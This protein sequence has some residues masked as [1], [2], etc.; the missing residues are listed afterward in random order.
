MKKSERRYS[1]ATNA[2]LDHNRWMRFIESILPC[3]ADKAN[4][5]ALYAKATGHEQDIHTKYVKALTIAATTSVASGLSLVVDNVSIVGGFVTKLFVKGLNMIAGI[6]IDR[7]F[8]TGG[9]IYETAREESRTNLNLDIIERN[10][11]KCKKDT[12]DEFSKPI[13]DKIGDDPEDN[14]TYAG[15]DA[16]KRVIIDPA[17]YVYEGV[18]SNRVEGVKATAYYR[19]EVEDIYGDIH[20][21]VQV[22]NAEDYAQENPL[23]TDKNGMYAWDVPPGE[24]QVK[25]EKEG[26]NTS[27]SEWLP[28]PPPDLK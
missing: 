21:N 28:V 10:K 11:L 4:A 12:D 20:M 23:Y 26:Y 5:E 16:E 1:W 18:H 3:D 17:G 6:I 27:Y 14:K 24:W 19:E 2:I 8:E 15:N 7:I 9:N 13:Y 25:F 22:W